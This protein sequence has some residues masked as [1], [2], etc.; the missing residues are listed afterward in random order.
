M[1]YSENIYL[2]AKGGQKKNHSIVLSR[3]N[4]LFSADILDTAINSESMFSLHYHNEIR[5]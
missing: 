3:Y 4:L 2:T 1:K 5:C